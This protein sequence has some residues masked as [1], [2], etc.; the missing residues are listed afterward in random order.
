MALARFS[1]RGG[2]I[3][4]YANNEVRPELS[5]LVYTTQKLLRITFTTVCYFCVF[6]INMEINL[7]ELNIIGASCT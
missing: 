3:Y 2:H 1:F 5:Y 4:V 6:V 7:M